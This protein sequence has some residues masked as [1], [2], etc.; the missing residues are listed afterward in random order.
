LVAGCLGAAFAAIV[1]LA[2]SGGRVTKMTSGDGLFY[3]YVAAHLDASEAGLSPVVAARGPSLRY[4]RIALPV[5]IWALSGGRPGAMPYAQPAIMIVA[6]GAIA[7][8][9]TRLLPKRSPLI[10]L[11]PFLAV[12]L[13]LSLAGGYTEAVAIA[14]VVWALVAARAERWVGASILLALGMLARENAAVIVVGLAAWCVWKQRWGPFGI[15]A[16]SLVPVAAWHLVVAARFGHLPLTDPY[17]WTGAQ[18]ARIPFVSLVR[19]FYDFSA[20]A[21]LAAAV[22]LGLGI[23]AVVLAIRQRSD[24]SFLAASAALQL[25]AVPLLNWEYAG[26]TFRL[27]S[28]LEVFTVLALAAVIVDRCSARAGEAGPHAQHD[29]RIA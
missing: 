24:L 14:F 18:T 2:Y 19:G 7:A 15:V 11:V 16:C 3:R 10:A 12:G 28:F 29:A 17:L 20:A 13:T 21:T 25:L 4:G 22:H 27:F 26:D 9:A 23:A 6:A 1:I 8:A 5:M